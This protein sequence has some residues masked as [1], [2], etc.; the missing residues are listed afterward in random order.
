MSI[1][2]RS[3]LAI[4]IG[5]IISTAY[6]GYVSTGAFPQFVFESSS[7]AAF[8]SASLLSVWL[9]ALIPASI[10]SSSSGGFSSAGSSADHSSN[11]KETGTVKW[12]N[13]SKGFGFITREEGDD[14]F[15][16]YRSIEGE[17]RRVLREG[18]EVAFIVTTGD[19]G[20]QAENVMVVGQKQRG[21][22]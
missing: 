3:V 19:K 20:P 2:L 17:G 11:D 15:V 12:F 16:H 9:S 18:Q 8:I 6:Q 7:A 21:D 5:L 4:V 1:F 13:A 10:A 14:V 22:R